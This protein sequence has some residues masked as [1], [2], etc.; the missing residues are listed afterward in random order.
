MEYDH[1]DEEDLSTFTLPA[2]MSAMMELKA[3]LVTAKRAPDHSHS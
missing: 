3:T 2:V 1:C